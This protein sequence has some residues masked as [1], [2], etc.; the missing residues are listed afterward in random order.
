MRVGDFR[1]HVQVRVEPPPGVVGVHGA[2]PGLVLRQRAREPLVLELASRLGC[3]L[4][5]SGALCLGPELLSAARPLRVSPRLSSRTCNI[6]SST[7]TVRHSQL[8]ALPV[9]PGV[10]LRVKCLSPNLG[11]LDMYD[12]RSSSQIRGQHVDETRLCLRSMRQDS[13]LGTC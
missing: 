2:L 13:T 3:S 1:P 7:S 5:V 12:S 9:L 4:T 6:G 8:L 11:Q 10:K